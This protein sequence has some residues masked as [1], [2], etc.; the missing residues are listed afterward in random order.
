MERALSEIS[1]E[2][3]IVVRN[4]RKADFAKCS[5][6]FK[7]CKDAESSECAKSSK[8]VKSSKCRQGVRY[9]NSFMNK[10][11]SSYV[12]SSKYVEGF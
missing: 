7:S 11:S 5:I 1:F 8:H 4:K 9:S 12:N 3:K 2:Y 10:G 6:Y